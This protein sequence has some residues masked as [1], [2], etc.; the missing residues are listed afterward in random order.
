[1]NILSVPGSAARVS[2]AVTPVQAIEPQTHDPRSSPLLEIDTKTNLPVPLHFPWLS[3]LP[4]ELEK[5]TRKLAP[6][7]NQTDLGE[8]LDAKV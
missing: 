5:A 3:R 2:P 4:V 8:L 7:G 1:M 6:F